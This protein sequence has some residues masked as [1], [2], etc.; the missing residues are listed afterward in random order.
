MA[1]TEIEKEIVAVE[2]SIDE[3]SIL[4]SE[5]INVTLSSSSSGTD[6]DFTIDVSADIENAIATAAECEASELVQSSKL[7]DLDDGNSAEPPVNIKD[8][9]TREIQNY[10]TIK[11]TKEIFEQMLDVFLPQ[12]QTAAKSAFQIK[13]HG[14]LE[15]QNATIRA[16]SWIP[17]AGEQLAIEKLASV[18][19]EAIKQGNEAAKTAAGTKKIELMPQIDAKAKEIIKLEVGANKEAIIQLITTAVEDAKKQ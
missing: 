10:V 4:T 18:K 15:S 12:M 2:K 16:L 3:I 14:Y 13:A 19:E 7:R 8:V 17:G 11:A 9:A 5:K 6:S 1:D